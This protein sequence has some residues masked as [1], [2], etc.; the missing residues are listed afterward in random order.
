MSKD[1]ITIALNGE[2]TLQ[3]FSSAISSLLALI[4]ALSREL[5]GGDSVRWLVHSLEVSSAIATARGESDVMEEVEKVVNAY[6]DV[7]ISLECGRRPQYSEKVVRITED[8]RDL[9]DDGVTSIR[10]ETPDTDAIISKDIPTIL[11]ERL[12]KSYGAIE[13]RIQTISNRKGLRFTLYDALNDRAVS[14]YLKEGQEDLIL[15]NWGKRAFVQ[16][17]ISRETISGRPVAIR[18]ITVIKTI[19]KYKLVLIL[20]QEELYLYLEMPI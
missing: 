3:R 19:Q 10:F 11:P 13:G 16:G 5:I 1:T 6:G 2:I 14:C 8:I 15:A 20:E 9:L 7:G 18:N 17:E 4:Q 12:I